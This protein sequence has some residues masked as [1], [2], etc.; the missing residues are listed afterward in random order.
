MVYESSVGDDEVQQRRV[1]I[2]M[3]ARAKRASME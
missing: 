3:S 2:V 1:D